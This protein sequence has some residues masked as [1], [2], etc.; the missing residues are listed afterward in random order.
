[1]FDLRLLTILF[2]FSFLSAFA[3]INTIELNCPP[4]NDFVTDNS[5]TFCWSSTEPSSYFDL[6]ISFDS[7]FTNLFIEVDSITSQTYNLD[8]ILVNNTFFWRVKPSSSSFNSSI[9]YLKFRTINANL[10]SGLELWLAADSGVLTDGSNGVQVWQDLSGNNKHAIQS[11]S[12][13]RPELISSISSLNNKPA[14]RFDGIGDT[15]IIDSSLSIATAFVVLNWSGTS[16]F[17]DFYGVLT[18]ASGARNEILFQS[19][20]GSEEIRD[21]S[22]FGNI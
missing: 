12:Q 16:P 19:L 8:S 22:M 11:K 15:M 17:D 7:L 1:M 4:N 5:V 13:S 6:Q 18:Q 9:P 20:N 3:Q 14:L 2:L 21:F 10:V